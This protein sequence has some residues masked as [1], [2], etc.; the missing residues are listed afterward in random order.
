MDNTLLS[1]DIR[2]V[3]VVQ[4]IKFCSNSILLPYIATR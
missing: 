4:N 3:Y 1:D 2:D